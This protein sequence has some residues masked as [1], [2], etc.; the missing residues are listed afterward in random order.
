[1]G[2]RGV[3]LNRFRCNATPLTTRHVRQRSHIVRTVRQF[4]QDDAHIA[5]HGQQHLAKRF[6]L[7]FLAG[8]KVQFVKLSK[9]VD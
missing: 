3:N 9:A 4:D 2:N 7:V 1:M 5:R 8:V 6:R